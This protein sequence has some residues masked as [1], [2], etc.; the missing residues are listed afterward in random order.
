VSLRSRTV[1]NVVATIAVPADASA[2]ERYAVIWAQVKTP[3]KTTGITTINRVGIRIY[4]SVGS[5]GGLASSFEIINLW[6]TR[7]TGRS[8]CPSADPK[9]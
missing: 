3:N 1:S 6:D 2:G 5:G 9:F 8:G 4:L 7:Q